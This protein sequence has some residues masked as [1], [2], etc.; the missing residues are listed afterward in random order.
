MTIVATAVLSGRQSGG[1]KNGGAGNPLAS[2]LPPET[3]HAMTTVLLRARRAIRSEEAPA[4]STPV[5][6]SAAAT[7]PVARVDLSSAYARSEAARTPA[8][9]SSLST[10]R[11]PENERRRKGSLWVGA[12]RVDAA[13]GG[14]GSAR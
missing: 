6:V 4:A 2:L 5:A 12:V 9:G 10:L 11:A 8:F 7:A 14:E 1:A 13:L 3:R